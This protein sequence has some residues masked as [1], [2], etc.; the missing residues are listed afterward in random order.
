[1]SR[2]E[3]VKHGGQGSIIGDIGPLS[4]SRL[5]TKDETTGRVSV[6]AGFSELGS[7][8]LVDHQ[9]RGSQWV[10]MRR[11]SPQR[12]LIIVHEAEC[13][14]LSSR[15]A[16]SASWPSC[17]THYGPLHPTFC[18]LSPVDQV[19]SPLTTTLSLSTKDAERKSH[20][21]VVGLS[22][23]LTSEP[24]RL[25]LWVQVRPA[26]CWPCTCHERA[27][28]FESLRLLPNQTSS[29]GQ[30]IMARLRCMSC[31]GLVSWRQ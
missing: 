2:R 1:M 19:S 9:H 18:H 21:A 30:L 14:V 17:P 12:A 22:V 8:A 6:G 3:S 20:C 11:G 7:S 29:R 10:M 5:K 31:G 27:S 24:G 15:T 13:Y 25:S 28:M 4:L 26:Y 23:L 16:L